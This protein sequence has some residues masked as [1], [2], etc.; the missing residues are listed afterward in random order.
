MERRR[1][2]HA[3]IYG[4]SGAGRA[5]APSSRR[6]SGLEYTTLVVTAPKA[7]MRPVIS[8]RWRIEPATTLRTKQSSPVTWYA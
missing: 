1:G 7:L 6:D 5:R 3:G 2:E 4:V 8:S